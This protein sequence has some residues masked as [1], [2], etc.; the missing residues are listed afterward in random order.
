M[1]NKPGIRSKDKMMKVREKKEE[2]S[3]KFYKIM[4][5]IVDCNSEIGTQLCSVIDNLICLRH[6]ITSTAAMHLK[7]ICFKRAHYVLSYHL[8]LIP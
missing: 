7:F 4:V 2:E 8:I 1:S 6:S 3:D 5:L